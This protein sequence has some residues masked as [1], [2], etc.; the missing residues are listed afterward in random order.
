MPRAWRVDGVRFSAP[1]LA[2][3]LFCYPLNDRKTLAKD[4][5]S[6]LQFWGSRDILN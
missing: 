3:G 2:R 4:L 6:F 1:L 5:V